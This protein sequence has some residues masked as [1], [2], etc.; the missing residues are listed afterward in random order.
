MALADVLAGA[1]VTDWIAA[2]LTGNVTAGAL[3]WLA[4]LAT[5]LLTQFA[6]GPAAAVV[7]S[8]TLFPVADA[9]GY[10]AAILARIIPGTADAVTLPWA[11]AAVAATFSF[12]AV[13]LGTMF[14]VGA[15]VTVL[16]SVVVVVL[17]MALVPAL[18][19]FTLP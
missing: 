17:S 2:L 9:V 4:G 10:N 14:R 19:A 18:Q 7:V 3:P 15:V 11:S 1:G 6:N 16:T 12:G 5:P 13:G 8:T